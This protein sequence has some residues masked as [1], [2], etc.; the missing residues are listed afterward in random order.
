[1]KVVLDTNVLVSALMRDGYT[2]TILLHPDLS[3]VTPEYALEEVQ[4]HLPGIADRMR[5]SIQ[6]AR[7]TVELL[8]EHIETVP[9]AEYR[10]FEARAE[11]L[12]AAVDP[13]DV[14]FAALAM[15]TGR[16]VWTQDKALLNCSG[17]MT[18]STPQLA[19][20]LGIG[21]ETSPRF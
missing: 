9:A 18:I 13:D 15:A 6:Q 12:I 5:T 3:L 21:G 17:L 4:R 7:L 11:E 2:R 14:Q 1:M 16:P 8:L 19:R 20:E 10:E